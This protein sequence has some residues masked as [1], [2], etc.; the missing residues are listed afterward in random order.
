MPST[1]KTK[2]G[3]RIEATANLLTTTSVLGYISNVARNELTDAVR[4]GNQTK[5]LAAVDIIDKTLSSV[6]KRV[7]AD[8]YQ[9]SQV[10]A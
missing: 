5:A 10:S 3:Q 8:T 9:A 2:I 6:K 7:R 1:A 4:E